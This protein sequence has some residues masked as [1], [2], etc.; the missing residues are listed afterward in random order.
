[1]REHDWNVGGR[2]DFTWEQLE[3]VEVQLTCSSNTGWWHLR[4]S[5]FTS[6]LSASPP[7]VSA[8]QYFRGRAKIWL[9]T[10]STCA[11]PTKFFSLLLAFFCSNSHMVN[12]VRLPSPSAYKRRK[13]MDPSL[14]CIYDYDFLWF[15]MSHSILLERRGNLYVK[16]WEWEKHIKLLLEFR[17]FKHTLVCNYHLSP[18]FSMVDNGISES[19]TMLYLPNLWELSG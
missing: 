5:I 7:R 14:S 11:K 2:S 10:S 8:N 12:I 16:K 4:R 9:K 18:C 1:M 13:I 6:R 3:V 17:S 19:I 15:L